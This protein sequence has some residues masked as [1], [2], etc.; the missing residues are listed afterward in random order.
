MAK[1]IEEGIK[2]PKKLAKVLSAALSGTVAALGVGAS[3][4]AVVGG[5]ITGAVAIPAG[6]AAGGVV[7]GAAGTTAVVGDS[8]E[9]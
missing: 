6:I 4:A 7:V 1:F 2:S 9:D 5:V 8:D 3:A